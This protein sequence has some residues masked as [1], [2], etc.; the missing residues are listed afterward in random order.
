MFS[1]LTGKLKIYLYA[2]FAALLPILYVLGR[3]DGSKINEVKHLKDDLET[4]KERAEFY[5]KMEAD[6][7]TSINNRDELIDRLRDT[8]L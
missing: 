1:L 4:E 3:K 6:E 5:K 2:A 7:S 8:G